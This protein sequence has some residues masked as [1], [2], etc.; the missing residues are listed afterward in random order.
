MALASDG[1]LD[2]KMISVFKLNKVY[3]YEKTSDKKPNFSHW[4]SF[5]PIKV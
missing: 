3:K 1:F 5:C 2:G 4:I